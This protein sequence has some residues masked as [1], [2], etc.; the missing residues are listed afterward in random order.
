M[1]T[2]SLQNRELFDARFSA[3]YHQ[4]ARHRFDSCLS[5]YE[6]FSGKLLDVGCGDGFFASLVKE[7]SN[8]SVYGVDI[9][10]EN[11]KKA[12]ARGVRIKRADI[13]AAKLP[14]SARSFDSVYCGEVLEHVV[15]TEKLLEEFK[16]VLKPNGFLVV[17]VPNIASWYNRLLLL[18]GQAPFWVESGARGSYGSFCNAPNLNGHVRAFNRRALAELLN[19]TGFSPVQWK[20]AAFNLPASLPSKKFRA[21]AKAFMLAERAFSARPSLSSTLIV[22]AVL[23]D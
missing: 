16:R 2:I 13:S 12:R 5:F 20:G 22:K 19:A 14:F 1:E 9:S 11:L 18:F 7:R 6:N 10:F 3:S 4:I 15:E 17:T 21:S 23:S 8:A